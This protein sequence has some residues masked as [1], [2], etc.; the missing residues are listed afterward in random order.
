MPIYS[1][2]ADVQIW[3]NLAEIY[4]QIYRQVYRQILSA[5][6][7]ISRTLPVTNITGVRGSVRVAADACGGQED[8]GGDE[9]DAE[10]GR[11]GGVGQ[12]KVLPRRLRRQGMHSLV[13]CS[14]GR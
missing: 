1:I 3:K 13:K 9:V 11:H 8:G 4:L 12:L 14:L 2:S 6:C 7:T 10:A 5:D